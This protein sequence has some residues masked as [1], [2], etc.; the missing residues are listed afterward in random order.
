MRQERVGGAP[1]KAL[2][3]LMCLVALSAAL[4]AC[5]GDDNKKE[6]SSTGTTSTAAASAGDRPQAKAALAKW[7]AL[8][9]KLN[10]AGLKYRTDEPQHASQRNLLAMRRD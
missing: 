6:S 8:T 2:A 3:L 5:G 10:A 9:G 1:M 4:A 7:I